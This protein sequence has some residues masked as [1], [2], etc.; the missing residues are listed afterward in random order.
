MIVTVT[1][2][3]LNASKMPSASN[4][5]QM[6]PTKRQPAFEISITCYLHQHRYSVFIKWE[7]NE[8]NLVVLLLHYTKQAHTKKTLLNKAHIFFNG[9]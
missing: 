9:N 2:S 4:R 5:V 3:P 8:C 6:Q 7:R 1:S